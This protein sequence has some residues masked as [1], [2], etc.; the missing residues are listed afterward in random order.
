MNSPRIAVTSGMSRRGLLAAGGSAGLGALL[1]ACGGSSGSDSGSPGSSGGKGAA[2]R[3]PAGPWTFTDDREKTVELGR[4]PANLV[5]Y[6]GSAAALHDY[7]VARIFTPA[8]HVA[9]RAKLPERCD[10][11]SRGGETAAGP[12]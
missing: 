8:D 9:S 3:T 12:A 11:R 2:A 10:R 5:A 4:T 7:G 1:A 6:V